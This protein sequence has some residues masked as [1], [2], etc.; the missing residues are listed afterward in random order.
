[1]DIHSTLKTVVPELSS[2]LRQHLMTIGELEHYE[3]D[4]LILDYG[5][6]ACFLPIILEGNARVMR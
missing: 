2:E 3:K 1:M 4:E 5:I 6:Q